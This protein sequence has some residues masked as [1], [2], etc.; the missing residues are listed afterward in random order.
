MDPVTIWSI[1]LVAKS[2]WFQKNNVLFNC[3][4]KKV[5]KTLTLRWKPV[6][7]VNGKNYGFISVFLLLVFLWNFVCDI[8][9]LYAFLKY[10]C[11]LLTF[12]NKPLWESPCCKRVPWLNINIPFTPRSDKHVTSPYSVDTL[13]SGKVVRLLKLIGY[14]ILSWLNTKFSQPVYKEMCS[15]KRTELSIRSWEIFMK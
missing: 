7:E 4:T 5:S 8:S 12:V 2:Q 15:S 9:S 11:L 1:D 14:K 6:L 3:N 10:M 13:S